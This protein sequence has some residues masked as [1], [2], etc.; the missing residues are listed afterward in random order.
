MMLE[1]QLRIS[2]ILLV[3]IF[4]SCK[5][6]QLRS[7]YKEHIPFEEE[8]WK[9]VNGIYTLI[10]TADSLE[11][12]NLRAFWSSVS[13]GS[14]MEYSKPDEL[15]ISIQS[16][17]EIQLI[18][19]GQNQVLDTYVL[20]GKTTLGIFNGKTDR[21]FSHS[22]KAIFQY[23]SGS[24]DIIRRPENKLVIEQNESFVFLILGLFPLGN[25]SGGRPYIFSRVR[26]LR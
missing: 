3:I 26:D 15:G 23:N 13:G 6:L 19:F 16:A 4:S 9:E 22:G 1:K 12:E 14:S 7:K 2:C 11:T 17:K 24:H 8:T 10:N 20:E 21:N 18:L 25:G 5:S